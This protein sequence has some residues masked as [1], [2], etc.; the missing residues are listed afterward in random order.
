M[1]LLIYLYQGLDILLLLLGAATY[2]FIYETCAP[3]VVVV[4]MSS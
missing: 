2:S 4:D 1:F 3:A